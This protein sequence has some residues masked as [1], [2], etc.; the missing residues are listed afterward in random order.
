MKALIQRVSEAAV[1]VNN[2]QIGAIKQGLL[3][4]LGIEHC[5]TEQDATKLAQKVASYRVFSDS[6]DKMNL[7]VQ[8]VQGGVLV[9]SQFTLAADT[10]SGRRPSFS[11]AALPSQAEPLYR[12][13]VAALDALGVITATGEFGADMAVSLINDGPVTFMLQTTAKG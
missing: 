9:V 4:L 6:N 2:Q 7:S 3:V 1:T 10:N 8:D 12:H 13:F 11:S 5:D